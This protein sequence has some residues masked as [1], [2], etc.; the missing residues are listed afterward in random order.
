MVARRVVAPDRRRTAPDTT[1]RCPDPGCDATNVPA[2]H[3]ACPPD[4]SRLPGG[5]RQDIL[6]GYRARHSDDGIAHRA[7]MLAAVD[8]YRRNANPSRSRNA[9]TSI[10]GGYAVDRVLLDEPFGPAGAR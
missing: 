4:W 5:L 10:R 7:A 6:D 3:F 8:W 9:G 1:H 2:R